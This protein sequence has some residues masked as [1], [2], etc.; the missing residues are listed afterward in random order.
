VIAHTPPRSYKEVARITAWSPHHVG[1]EKRTARVILAVKNFAAIKGV[2]HIGLGVTATNTLKV[3]RRAGVYCETWATQTFEELKRQ[4]EAAV[5]DTLK[6]G[7]M[8]ITHVVVSAPSWV[9][10]QDF[11]W[12]VLT[13]PDIEFV[14]LSHSGCAFLSIDKFGIRNIREDIDLELTV[15]NFRVAANNRR[16][17]DF[18]T[19]TYGF[20]CLYL[21]NLYDCESFVDP[22]PM[23]KDFGG[24]IRIG[25]FG[26]SRPWK[27]Q[28][29]AAEASIQLARQLGVNLELYV[30]SKRP[31]G[32][33]RM[34][35]SRLE[36]FDNMRGCKIVDVP[37]R[38]GPSSAPPVGTCIF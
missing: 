33:E 8:P 1:P 24:T 31:D 19:R 7:K 15:H 18:L 17:T 22:Y 5:E 37:W 11:K 14:M 20:E 23:H 10:P 25:S 16:V 30:N 28:L 35:E 9:Q 3:L 21:P 13:Y 27:N 12:L 26:A 36:M 2:C 32:G 4:L 38:R 29:C 6:H 34:I